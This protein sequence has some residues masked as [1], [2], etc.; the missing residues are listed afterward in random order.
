MDRALYGG[1]Y[2]YTS[3]TS[4]LS[5]RLAQTIDRPTFISLLINELPAEMKIEKSALLLLEGN[6]LELQDPRIMPFPFHMTMRLCEILS[7]DQRPVRAQN[8]WNLVSPE[9]IERWKQFHGLNSLCRSFIGT[10]YTVS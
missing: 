5:N 9:T 1:Y 6:N 4:D 7:A 3:V 10:L 8:L 2:D